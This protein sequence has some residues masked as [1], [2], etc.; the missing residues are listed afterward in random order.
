MF[1]KMIIVAT[2]AIFVGS[3]AAAVAKSHPRHRSGGEH[4]YSYLPSYGYGPGF[5]SVP[6]DRHDPTNT[7]GF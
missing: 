6:A 7:N 3:T 4:G 2:V 1:R 5:G